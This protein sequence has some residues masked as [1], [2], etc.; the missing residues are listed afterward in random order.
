MNLFY[1]LPVFCAWCKIIMYYKK[2]DKPNQVSHGICE[3]CKPSIYAE[4]Y[5]N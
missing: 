4:I 1:S 3:K 5:N 2:T